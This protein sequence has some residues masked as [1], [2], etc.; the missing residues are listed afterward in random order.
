MIDDPKPE[1]C[2]PNVRPKDRGGSTCWVLHSDKDRE[3]LIIALDNITSLI[4]MVRMRLGLIEMSLRAI[5]N[6]ARAKRHIPGAVDTQLGIAVKAVI[7][8]L[9][10]LAPKLAAVQTGTY[11][12]FGR[13][14]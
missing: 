7:P 10:D 4:P 12:L 8:N 1:D 9:L 3:E 5:L 6:D 11:F 2:I 13:G 14:H